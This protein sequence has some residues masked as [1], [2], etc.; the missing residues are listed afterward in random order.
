MIYEFDFW[1]EEDIRANR[2]A[3]DG[4]VCVLEGNRPRAKECHKKVYKLITRGSIR[5]DKVGALCE[6]IFEYEET[7]RFKYEQMSEIN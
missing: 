7:L 1:T 3:L 2:D 5:Y 4:W 6:Y